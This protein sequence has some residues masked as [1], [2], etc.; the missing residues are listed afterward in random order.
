MPS[1]VY[2]QN[3]T[4]E[5]NR[6]FHGSGETH[7]YSAKAVGHILSKVLGFSARRRGEGYG[8][9]LTVDVRKKIH[10]HAKAMRLNRTDIMGP[11]TIS[12]SCHL[13]AEFDLMTDHEGQ[14]VRS[15]SQFYET[16]CRNCRMTLQPG[17]M[18]CPH[19]EM[20]TQAA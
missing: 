10:S 12:E 9:V 11:N 6:I 1:A 5:T 13:C 20:S 4:D 3:V 16:V 8:I 2:D 7:T 17:V 14:S 18:R 19:C 15:L